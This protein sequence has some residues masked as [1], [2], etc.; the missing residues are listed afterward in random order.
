[1]VPV[2]G[3]PPYPGDDGRP[4]GP[5]RYPPRMLRV[6]Q[7]IRTRLVFWFLLLALAPIVVLLLTTTRQIEGEVEDA[8]LRSIAAIA[9]EKAARLDAYA[10]ERVRSV[11]SISTG[12][13]FIGAAEELGA[14]YEADGERNEA[15]YDAALA[16]YR[17]RIESFASICEFPSFMILDGSGRVVYSL[18]ETPLLHRRLSEPALAGLGL[19]RVLPTVR[20]EKKAFI[21]PAQIA[22]DDVRPSLEVVGPLVKSDAVVGFVA[23]QLAPEEIDRI[24]AD[25]SGLGRTGDVL[26]AA[27][28][29][30]EVVVTTPTRDDPNAA[31]RLRGRIGSDFSRRLQELIHGTSFRGRGTDTQGH[32]VIGAWTRV[33]TLGW[34]IAVTQHLDEVI[35]IAYS[36]ERAAIRIGGYLILPIL[37][38]GWFIARGVSKPI[39]AAAAAAE[40]LAAA[41]LSVDIRERGVGETRAMLGAMRRATNGLV[42]LLRRVRASG[43]S[44]GAAAERIRD[45]AREQAEIAQQ[46]GASS[47]EIAAAVREITATQQELNDAMQAVARSVREASAAAGE[48]RAALVGLSGE[49]GSLAAGADG[50]ARNLESIRERADR[51]GSV[52][53]SMAKVANQTNL[54]S[55][56]AAMEAERAGEAGA[57]FRAVAREIRRLSE[58]TADAALSIE[59]IVNEMQ[60]AVATGVEEMSRYAGSVQGGVQKAQAIGVE[61]GTVIGGV[62]RLGGEVDLVARGMEAQALGVTQVSQAIATLT[63]GA[64]R[65]AA[66]AAGASATGDELGARAEGFRREVE[67][68]R[69]PPE[70]N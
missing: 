4:S 33:P 39:E 2:G 31:F 52:V 28:I 61:L 17:P 53:A 30:G 67:A 6:L 7:S 1:M 14:S 43:E 69:L 36:Q 5:S 19:A 11:T 47:T 3:S 55:V 35:G 63:E 26:C 13:A 48:G 58:Q 56:N 57:G 59:A 70:S 45:S 32:E 42:T 50:I 15:A 21:T 38:L 23:V 8:R 65:T 66:V 62:E 34:G 51:I 24:V 49:I 64:S 10:R 40:R 37:I 60:R 22:T 12:L 46:F 44:L 9:E 27:R 20:N 54:L 29:G 68:F 41:D 16:K 25:Y 18:R